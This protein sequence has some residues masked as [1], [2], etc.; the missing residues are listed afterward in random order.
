MEWKFIYRIFVCIL[1]LELDIGWTLELL[2]SLTGTIGAENY[3]YYRL[4]RTGRIKV[5]LVS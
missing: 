5:E 3:T 2:Q 4:A 1:V